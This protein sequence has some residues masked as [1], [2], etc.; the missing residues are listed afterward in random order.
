MKDDVARTSL[1]KTTKQAAILN[2][3]GKPKGT[4]IDAI[5]EVT[6]WQQHSVRGFLA[7]TVR[8]KLG[9]TLVSEKIDGQRVYRVPEKKPA[10]SRATSGKSR[11]A[12]A[13]AS[14]IA[15]AD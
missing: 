1:P 3:L 2:L 7:G 11:S 8:K 12:P 10:K 6:G 14:P 5:M 13:T 15:S 4:T 9:L